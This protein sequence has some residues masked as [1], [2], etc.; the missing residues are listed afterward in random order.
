MLALSAFK[1]FRSNAAAVSFVD[2]D[3][4]ASGFGGGT[5]EGAAWDAGNSWVEITGTNNQAWNLPDSA[6]NDWID[7]TNNLIL[8]HMDETSWAGV[9]DEVVDDSGNGYH[10]VRSGNATTDAAGQLGYTGTFDGTGD[11]IN[12]GDN[13]ALNTNTDKTVSL[14]VNVDSRASAER[15]FTKNRTAN[16]GYGMAFESDGD[17]AVYFNDGSEMKQGISL[18]SLPNDSWHHVVSVYDESAGTVSNYLDG[19][20]VSYS[21]GGGWG[22]DSDNTLEVGGRSGASQWFDGKVDEFAIFD[23]ILTADEIATMYENQSKDYGARLTSRIYDATASTDWATLSWVTQ[24]PVGKELPDAMA[25]ET[26][27]TSGNIG[28]GNNVGLWHLNEDSWDGTADEVVDSSGNGHHGVRSGNATTVSGGKFGNAGTFDGSGDYVTIAD[29]PALDITDKITIS[30]WFKTSVK[31]NGIIS[32]GAHNSSDNGDYVL[33]HDNVNRIGFGLNNSVAY[34]RSTAT[35]IDGEWH[36]VVGTYDKDA[37]GVDEM[38]LYVDGVL[39]EVGDYSTAISTSANDLRIGTYYS[40]TYNFDGDI[41]EVAIWNDVLSAT[42]IEAMYRRGALKL[43]LQVRSCDDSAC[44]GETWMGPDGTVS[45][46]YNELSTSTV[47]LP[48]K[49]LFNVLDNQYFQYRTFFETTSST[50]TPE[51]SSVTLAGTSIDSPGVT[52]SETTQAATEGGVTDTYTVVLDA[53][54]TANVDIAVSFS[55][56]EAT[57]TPT[58]TLTFTTGN[59]D[60][61]QTL[62]VTAV[63]DSGYDSTHYTKIYHT[64]S[65]TDGNYN[66]IS[67]ADVTVTITDNDAL[68]GDYIDDGD[69]L[70]GFGGGTTTSIQWSTSSW[71]MEMTGTGLTAGVATHT[72]RIMDA[73]SAL[74]WNT[75]S[76]VPLRPL[77]KELPDSMATET[78]YTD[79]NVGMGNNVGLWHFNESSWSGVADEVTDSSGNGNHGVRSGDATTIASGKFD[80]AGTFDGTGDDILVGS[81]GTF[82]SGIDDGFT[83]SFWTKWDH[84]NA[85]GSFLGGSNDGATESFHIFGNRDGGANTDAGEI[86]FW[87]K[88]GGLALSGGTGNGAAAEINKNDGEWH[89]ILLTASSISSGAMTL[90][91]DGVSQTLDFWNSNTRTFS[92]NFEN[93]AIGGRYNGSTDL[94]EKPMAADIDEVA[95]LNKTVTASEVLDLYRR[96]V[97][98]LK[99]QV[100]SCDDGACS[101]ESFMGPDGTATTYYTESTTSS[102]GLP[103]KT[104]FNV[105]ANRYFQYQAIFETSSSTLNVELDSVTLAASAGPGVTLS[106]TT[107]SATEGGVSD[108]YTVVLDAAPTANVDIALN[109]SNGE[110]TTTP[111]STLTFT[112][113]NWDTAQTLT[114]Q[115]VDDSGYDSTHY[116]KIYHTASSTDGNYNA[117]SIS[118]VTVTITDND[119]LAADYIDDGDT[120]GGFGGGTTS[121]IQWSTSS[122]WM[123]MTG[124]GLTAGVATHTSRI[125]DAGSSISWDTL[126]WVPARPLTK[127]LPDSMA[128]ETAYTNG[129]V[130]MGNN[131]GLWHFNE[132]SGSITDGSGNSHSGTV[133]G[134]T[135]GV[136]GM[137]DTAL[138]FDGSD[139]ISISDANDLS[140]DNTGEFSVSFWM[141]TGS[142]V[143]S[144][145]MLVQKGATTSNAAFEWQIFIQTDSKLYVTSVQSDGDTIRRENTNA[146]LLAN[147]WYHVVAVYSGTGT[148]DD[149]NIYLDGV[150]QATTIANPG[151]TT[152]TNG[153]HPLYVGT[154]YSGGSLR[155][156]TGTIDELSIFNDQISAAEALAMYR[157]GANNLKFQVRSCDDASCVGETFMGP[158]GTASTYYTESTTS[159]VGLPS[160]SLLNLTANRYFQ[161]QAIF[162]TSSSTLNTE[163]SSVTLAGTA[164]NNAPTA[165]SISPSQITASVVQFSTTIA[166]ADSEVTTLNVDYSTDNVTWASTTFSNVS[167]DYGAVSTVTGT[168]SGIDTNSTSSVTLTIDWDIAE[169]LPNTD[170]TS[171][172]LR[173]IPNDGTEN[174]TTVSSSAFTI[175]TSDPSV[176]GDLAAATITS[177]TATF[178]FPNTTSTDSNFKEYKIH[179]DTTAIVTTADSA[180]TSS[181]DTNLGSANF[182]FLGTSGELTGLTPN[183]AYYFNLFAYDDWANVTSSA[184][185]ISTTTLAA[186]PGTPTT[187]VST[188]TQLD[189]SWNAS[190]NAAGTVYELYNVTTAASV[191][192]TTATTYNVTGLTANTAYQFKVRAENAGASGTYSSYSG[193][194]TA[195]Y[196]LAS[197]V[198]GLSATDA[199]N[200]TTLQI[201]LSWTDAG[202]TGMVIDRDNGCDTSYDVTL[203]TSST[204]NETSPTTTVDSISANTC[205][206]YRIR[207]YNAAGVVNSVSVASDQ[208]TTPPGQTQNVTASSTAE[209]SITWAWDAVTGAAGYY[210]YNNSTGGL[211][212]TVV[213]ATEYLHNGLTANTAYQV[214]V[215][216]YHAVNGS[217]IASSLAGAV[218]DATT[219]AGLTVSTRATSSITWTWTD[220]GQTH[221]YARDA[222]NVTD[223]T[224]WITSSTWQ[225]TSLTANTAYDLEVNAR[226]ASTTETGYSGTITRYTAQNAPDS[227]ALSAITTSSITATVT[228]TFAN[229]GTGSALIH[230]DNGD[231]TTQDITSGDN[232]QNTGLSPST[233]YTYTVYAQNSD[234]VQTDSVT[235][236][237]YTLANVPGQITAALTSTSSL[238]LTHDRNSNPVATNARLY[239]TTTEQYVDT[240]ALTLVG[241]STD[242][243]TYSLWGP[244][245]T[246]VSGLDL[247]TCYQFSA[248]ARNGDNTLTASSTASASTC[249]A[250]AVPTSLTITVDGTT[251]MTAVWLANGNASTTAYYI[252]DANATSTNSGWITTTTYQFTGL[253]E[254]T[255]Y[256]FRVKARNSASVETDYLSSTGQTEDNS[257]SESV[258]SESSSGGGGGS[259]FSKSVAPSSLTKIVLPKNAIKVDNSYVLPP[260]ATVPPKQ[261]IAPQSI[262]P[263]PFTIGTQKHSIRT[264][265]YSPTSVRVVIR[266]EPIITTLYK[267]KPKDIDTD[268]DGTKDMRVEYIGLEEGLPKYEFTLLISDGEAGQ[269]VTINS[270]SVETEERKVLLTMNFP[271]ATD[272]AISNKKDFSDAGFEPYATSTEWTLSEGLGEKHVYVRF[273]MYDDAVIDAYDTINGVGDNFIILE[274]EEIIE[275]QAAVKCP[276]LVNKPYQHPAYQGIYQVIGN[277]DGTCTRRL[278][279]TPEVYHSHYAS[280][281]DIYKTSIIQ[282]IPD[283]VDPIMK[284]GH[285][286]NILNKSIIKGE[287]SSKVYFVVAPRKHWIF[288]EAI[289]VGLKFAWDKIITV[290]EDVIDSFDT[291]QA[292]MSNPDYEEVTSVLP[293]DDQPE[294][295]PE[296]EEYV[297][298]KN[299]SIGD[300]GVEVRMLQQKLYEEGFFTHS[301]MTGYYGS[302]TEKAVKAYQTSNGIDPVGR[303]GPQTIRALN[304]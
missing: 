296:P 258:E 277:E 285:R 36:H 264:Q 86:A 215:R 144:R 137:L 189:V 213:A 102:L 60:T 184:S 104:L 35:T 124:T 135:Y 174:G 279:E 226:N 17:L 217:G 119:S 85:W 149:M 230:F 109:F 203:F 206:E 289:F 133:T 293:P 284:R 11:Y 116:T 100:R 163:L 51:L 210:I 275:E 267:G 41:D 15:I 55:N 96:G 30:A 103:A 21:V 128:T 52:L 298:S 195:V 150:N 302:I 69:T 280:K 110:A 90:Y 63:D 170:D 123:E 295:T 241:D 161:Y 67:I 192:T 152:Y 105:T 282:W 228:G 180:L 4:T 62:T 223:N 43:Q 288:S 24:W 98:N 31:D 166:D 45:S 157:R 145:Q 271:D 179:Y 304:K 276:L 44:S 199:T 168:I 49:T 148:T 165:T 23:E 79:G 290:P 138:S 136:T 9:A 303:V 151:G 254:G 255:S 181:T 229:N 77:T 42:D 92:D 61:A 70:G 28:M 272:M 153:T 196:T 237:A 274:P 59:W 58:T 167:V 191:G 171:V 75:L 204:A 222:N 178:T 227:V 147:T 232:W 8:L 301:S 111:T 32:K 46:Y 234:A 164:E 245:T 141:K 156:F 248:V 26:A 132:T 120:L 300:E 12:M 118:D 249:T 256:T 265:R 84:S 37:G 208:I 291:G 269:P 202:Q 200:T 10:G 211:I 190:S 112:T 2:N 126:S 259:V 83:A 273:R 25:T 224:G 19:E 50:L 220:S 201:I 169:D 99:F 286:V 175:D 207:S 13:A 216:A 278:F 176:P 134:A 146:T 235:S 7:M 39:E 18:A 78:A 188:T 93:F 80:R 143:T 130:G 129:N 225:Q 252:E 47:G 185:E 54:P 268:A 218:T 20:A 159:T 299:L 1:I 82:L 95:L 5:M 140:L 263:V 177:S 40:N 250:A 127:E 251:A 87:F 212:D 74:S 6:A 209:T 260:A 162:E 233:Q 294:I 239:E 154:G 38:K 131:V 253:T 53:A 205:Y 122:W 108:T 172:Y 139:Y 65:S 242:F 76:W 182:N 187:V 71:W 57:T 56:A 14:W 198:T 33:T 262:D 283:D 231:G 160:K 297:F 261:V 292:I 3:N 270:G 243:T 117:I 244:T 158:D 27:Y 94:V 287:F 246:V 219:P 173:V 238:T 125:M 88:S 240:T 247:N 106:E 193:N 66:A 194:S 16:L 115:A 101:G 64:A 236:S 72:S 155:Y 89:H 214:V 48:A 113:G 142:D 114:V 183:T 73:G 91:V 81:L 121:S 68:A 281:D 197:A 107:Q 34:I 97:R 257:S 266:S 29:D 221:F 22:F 186:V